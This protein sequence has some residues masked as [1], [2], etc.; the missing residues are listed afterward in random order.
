M[1]PEE[2]GI[3]PLAGTKS[4]GPLLRGGFTVPL[5]MA[6]RARHGEATKAWRRELG[7]ELSRSRHDRV[8]ETCWRRPGDATAWRSARYAAACARV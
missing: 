7:A 6:R 8:D 3:A 1:A 5:H 2:F 4:T